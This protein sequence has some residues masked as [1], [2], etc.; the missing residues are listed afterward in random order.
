M[1]IIKNEI[2]K[3]SIG[4]ILAWKLRLTCTRKPTEN[5]PLEILFLG[6][7]IMAQGVLCLPPRTVRYEPWI[8]L[9]RS[10]NWL[11]ALKKNQRGH[12]LTENLIMPPLCGQTRSHG[13]KMISYIIRSVVLF[14][15][16]YFYLRKVFLSTAPWLLWFANK[17]TLVDLSVSK[18][19]H[20]QRNNNIS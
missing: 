4:S 17:Y 2:C 7:W 1:I 11:L 12:C 18:L 5:A 16:A 20:I 8:K 13:C 6:M 10:F 9:V 19:I 15:F 3:T 14:L